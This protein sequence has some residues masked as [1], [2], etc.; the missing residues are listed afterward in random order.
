MKLFI[1]EGN[2]EAILIQLI[3]GKENIYFM[4]FQ[5]SPREIL[6]RKQTEIFRNYE[7]IYKW[8]GKEIA[9][10][11]GGIKKLRKLLERL[12]N[13]QQIKH[14]A[15][16]EVITICDNERD[17][18]TVRVLKNSINLLKNSHIRFKLREKKVGDYFHFFEFCFGAKKLKLLISLPTLD[19]V[20]KK[21]TNEYLKNKSKAEKVQLLQKVIASCKLNEFF[22]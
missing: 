4:D 11:E 15:C 17:K 5:R 13:E 21:I 2:D 9:K 16:S 6:K 18:G 14:V 1:C 19:D 22:L 7:I 10:I 3:Y 12:V 20:V 8:K